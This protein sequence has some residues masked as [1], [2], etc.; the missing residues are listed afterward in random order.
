MLSAIRGYADLIEEDLAPEARATPDLDDMARGARAISTAADRAAALTHQLLA[1]ARQQV[2]Q[3]EVLE[4][5]KVVLG[6]EPMLNPLIGER[7]RLVLGLDADTGNIRADAGQLDQIIINL[8]VNARDALP[9]GGTIT[10]QTA[11]HTIEEAYAMEHFGVP[12]GSY[13]M[14]AVG[15]D[16]VGMDT[17]TRKHIFE[18][19]FTTKQ[20]GRGTGLGLATMFGIVRQSGGHIWLY[21]EPGRG[22]MFKLYFP[23]VEAR[24]EVAARPAAPVTRSASGTLLVVEDEDLVRDLIVNVLGRIGYSVIVAPDGAAALSTL[25]SSTTPIAAVVS[26]VVMPGMTGTELAKAV[27]DRFP[28]TGMLLLSGYT[29]ETLDLVDVLERG[30]RFLTKPFSAEQLGTAVASSIPVSSEAR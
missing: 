20:V 22:T 14:L 1:F 19:F 26:D 7:I 10:I 24:S 9:N 13:V 23:R 11:N 2:L 12:P 27:V 29:A 6:V 15:D 25:E 16:G 5:R 18:P 8:V 4:L 3:P 30:A 28:E 21:S 17:E